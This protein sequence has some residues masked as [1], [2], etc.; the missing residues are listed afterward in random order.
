[1]ELKEYNLMY[2]L[3][4]THW[5]FLGKRKFISTIF[6]K[7]KK[8]KILD[9][10]AGTGGTT[11]FLKKYGEVVGLEANPLAQTLA[12]KRGLKIVSGSAEKLP[13][14]KETFE[15]VT[16][17]D[18]LYHQNIGSDLKVLQEAHRVL[19]TQGYLVVTDCALPFLKSPHDEVMQARERY[20]KKELTQK[21]EKAGFKVEKASYVFF[22]VFP[23]TLLKRLLDR[24][25]KSHSS[26]V[27]PV[28]KLLNSC[29]LGICTLEAWFL[30]F[31]TLPWGSSLIIRAKKINN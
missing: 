16:I 31:G 18:V 11:K 22:L 26:N 5:W 19:R 24:L 28:P 4:N 30:K 2:E 23:L 10:G 20:T 13:F 27:S 17:F 8:V 12:R 7:V 14:E 3:E 29:L 6:P 9:I 15:V 1:M 25:T 21:I